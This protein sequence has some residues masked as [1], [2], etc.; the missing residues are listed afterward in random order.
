VPFCRFDV[1]GASDVLEPVVVPDDIIVQA[2]PVLVDLETDG[3]IGRNTRNLHC[4]ADNGLV[5]DLRNLDEVFDIGFVELHEFEIGVVCGVAE[6][7]GEAVCVFGLGCCLHLLHIEP[8]FCL[9]YRPL[10]R[11]CK[12]GF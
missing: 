11:G 12:A 3:R 2:V 7:R 6:F 4:M 1:V 8:S 10:G 5:V 9:I